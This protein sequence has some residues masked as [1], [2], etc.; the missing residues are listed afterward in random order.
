MNK[1]LAFRI[2]INCPRTGCVAE[3]DYTSLQKVNVAL[4][5]IIMAML[6]SEDDYNVEVID[7]LTNQIVKRFTQ[8]GEWFKDAEALQ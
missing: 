2:R 5:G 7:N 3:R 6:A 1:Q 8:L 4:S